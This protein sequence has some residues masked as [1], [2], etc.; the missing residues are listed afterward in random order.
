MVWCLLKKNIYIY[1]IRSEL[2][3]TCTNL[4]YTDREVLLYIYI[5]IL[6]VNILKKKIIVL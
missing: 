6:K 3:I 5:N 2:E 4:I 1:M